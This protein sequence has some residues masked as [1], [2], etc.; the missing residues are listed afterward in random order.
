MK[1]LPIVSIIRHLKF[2]TA[3]VYTAAFVQSAKPFDVVKSVSLSPQ[4]VTSFNQALTLPPDGTA[5]YILPTDMDSITA[6]T[7][8]CIISVYSGEEQDTAFLQ[9]TTGSIRCNGQEMN[10]ETRCNGNIY[11]LQD[12][13]EL[14]CKNDAASKARVFTNG[15]VAAV[16][17]YKHKGRNYATSILL[18]CLINPD[19]R[20]YV[21]KDIIS[22]LLDNNNH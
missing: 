4:L 5:Q 3:I 22:Q 10:D 8:D 18:K 12:S 1:H 20:I 17:C 13:D 16:Y 21:M 14:T 7:F 11:A 15:S 2:L 9:P 19:D 6:D